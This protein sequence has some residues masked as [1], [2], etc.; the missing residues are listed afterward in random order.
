MHIRKALDT[1][2]QQGFTPGVTAAQK[3]L[4]DL[5]ADRPLFLK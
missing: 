2:T 4:E 3:H 5:D 1:A